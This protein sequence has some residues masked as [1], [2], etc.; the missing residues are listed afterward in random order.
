MI[1]K[2]AF[3]KILQLFILLAFGSLLV[4]SGTQ[5]SQDAVKTEKNLKQIVLIAQGSTEYE[6]QVSSM[7]K[8]KLEAK[9]I[10]VKVT[11]IGLLD[12]EDPK[13]FDA[14]LLLH[15]VEENTLVN[16]AK[17]FLRKTPTGEA[18]PWSF[19]LVSTVAGKDWISKESNVDGV[20]AATQYTQA[21]NVATL[22]IGRVETILQGKYR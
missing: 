14:V 10:T 7:I 15:A 20:T 2:G 22:L 6:N 8:A 9:N 12:Q 13:S 17:V 4:C 3:M 11:S 16:S 5:N 1:N 19:V 18:G 21:K